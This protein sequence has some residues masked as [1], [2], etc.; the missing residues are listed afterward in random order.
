[1]DFMC[2]LK[3]ERSRRLE[4]VKFNNS[5]NLL[6]LSTTL[7]VNLQIRL[8]QWGVVPPK[9]LLFYLF[10]FYFI[11][12]SFC[13]CFIPLENHHCGVVVV[14]VVVVQENLFPG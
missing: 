1:M 5:V 2:K 10:F 12:F 7:K 11:I 9:L 3:H 14:V 8:V 6:W 13:F 4:N